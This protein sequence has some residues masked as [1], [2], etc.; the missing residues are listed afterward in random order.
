MDLTKPYLEV[1]WALRA[2]SGLLKGLPK[3][4]EVFGMQSHLKLLKTS[5]GVGRVGAKQAVQM[6][7]NKK[8]LCLG[9]PG[10]EAVLRG[11]HG[12]LKDGLLKGQLVSEP[13]CLYVKP[14]VSKREGLGT[15]S[16][17]IFKPVV[18]D[19]DHNACDV[20]R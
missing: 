12:C 14:F 2:L 17:G 16:V 20:D 7:G 13:V 5:D 11:V 19:R 10:P 6:L 3:A 1:Q 18:K 8:C 4:F 9:L 15:F